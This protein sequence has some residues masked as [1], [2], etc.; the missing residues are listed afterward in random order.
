MF[1]FAW[2][3]CHC[4]R[5]QL[6]KPAVDRGLIRNAFKLGTRGKFPSKLPL[7]TVLKFLKFFAFKS[8][9]RQSLKSKVLYVTYIARE[10]SIAHFQKEWGPGTRMGARSVVR[11]F[12][13]HGVENK[14]ACSPPKR[15]HNWTR[16]H[17]RPRFPLFLKVGYRTSSQCRS[18]YATITFFLRK[19]CRLSL[20]IL[21][22]SVV[23]KAGSGVEFLR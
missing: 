19:S 16:A 2:Q 1:V 7:I 9:V 5:Y 6:T 15:S 12:G 20:Q 14:C 8:K 4:W 17:R 22:K 13:G 23:A 3:A 18:P 11:S 21:S 10:F